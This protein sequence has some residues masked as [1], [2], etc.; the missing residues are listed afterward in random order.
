MKKSIIIAS[1]CSSFLLPSTV[2]GEDINDV[3]KKVNEYV[4]QKNYPKAMEELSWAQKE[5]EKLH[6]ERLSELLPAEVNGFKGGET[7]VQQMMGFSNIERE[8][9]NGEKTIRIAITGTGG[10]E[11]MGGLAGLAKMGMMMGATQSGRQQFRINGRTAN[12]DTT[13]DSPELSI[14]LESGALMQ[15]TSSGEGVDGEALK[16]F[17]EGLKI[18]ELDTYLKG[19]KN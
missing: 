5:L 19:S 9:S 6:Q 10:T 18:A 8:Y 4:Q 14:F 15:L 13:N 11:G 7:Q 1:I 17:A 3:F 12:L 2:F 16:K